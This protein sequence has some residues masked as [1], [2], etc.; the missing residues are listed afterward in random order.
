MITQ[1]SWFRAFPVVAYAVVAIL[2][3]S[4]L[5][6]IFYVVSLNAFFSGASATTEADIVAIEDL[7]TAVDTIAVVAT[8]ALTVFAVVILFAFTKFT[9]AIPGVALRS[10]PYMAVVGSLVPVLSLFWPFRM[11]SD[12]ITVT[13]EAGR[14]RLLTALRLYWIP[15]AASGIMSSIAFRLV[16]TST[17]ADGYL[18][19]YV[20][21][22]LYDVLLVAAALLARQFYSALA[23]AVDAA[24]ATARDT[25][26]SAEANDGT[27]PPA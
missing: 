23:A 11:Y 21:W 15:F 20:V 24:K 19:G 13:A 7:M 25:T 8:I 1:N 4:A 9:A 22:V 27:E 10:K 2:G 14:S 6:E 16:S 18:A 12:I 26:D 17:T 5:L 3:I